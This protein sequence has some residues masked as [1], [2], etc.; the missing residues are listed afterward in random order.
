MCYVC[1]LFVGSWGFAEG[2][3]GLF[4]LLLICSWWFVVCRLCFWWLIG[5]LW[6]LF[7]FSFVFGLFLV[8]VFA[9]CLSVVLVFWNW[10]VFFFVRGVFWVLII[11]FLVLGGFLF[12]LVGFV[13]SFL[14][15][16]FFGFLCLV[17]FVVV[18]FCLL[19]VFLCCGM[20]VLVF[21]GIWFF[22]VLW[23]VF[24]VWCFVVFFC[25]FVIGVDCCW[26]LVL[27]WV[28]FL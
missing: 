9:V 6:V 27:C 23:V 5:C 4:L 22:G 25:M 14:F 1:L 3:L 20:V 26:F 2:L 16:L 17:V 19:L 11:W 12:L 18:V 24:G 10:V 15:C 21:F 7:L 8:N 28:F 13:L